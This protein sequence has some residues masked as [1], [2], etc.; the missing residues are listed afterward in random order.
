VTSISVN[1]IAAY[2]MVELSVRQTFAGY[3]G[4]GRPLSYARANLK[5]ARR[6][7]IYVKSVEEGRRADDALSTL[8]SLLGS[9]DASQDPARDPGLIEWWRIRPRQDAPPRTTSTSHSPGGRFIANEEMLRNE[10]W[11][12]TRTRLGQAIELPKVTPY[13]SYMMALVNAAVYGVVVRVS[14]TQGPDAAGELMGTIGL[15]REAVLEQGEVWRLLSGCLVQPDLAALAVLL[16]GMTLVAPRVEASLGYRTFATAYL[17][18]ALVAADVVV[19]LGGSS[20]EQELLLAA[21]PA[22]S[23]TAAEA[24]ATA[25]AAAAVPPDS[26]VVL[27]AVLHP[28]GQALTAAAAAAGLGALGA[29][30]GMAGCA[31]AHELI[32]GA[33]ERSASHSKASSS[34]SSSAV[35]QGV[36]GSAVRAGALAAGCVAVAVQHLQEPGG[37]ALVAAVGAALGTGFALASLAGPRYQITREV[38]LPSGS[39]WIPDPDAVEEVTVVLDQTPAIQ[40]MLASGVLAVMAVAG[41][42][43]VTLGAGM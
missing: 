10:V 41:S 24:A 6:P 15:S 23:Q 13:L 42:A 7:A 32:N 14:A 36:S 26:A 27:E 29:V 8:D 21:A 38:E 1:D 11:A 20:S 33:V 4:C 22:A 34:G 30:A 28:A 12:G 19:A 5:T 39:M 17:L 2:K 43:A 35:Q 31:L 9:A 16:A 40:R 3:K 18:S 37:G 25:V